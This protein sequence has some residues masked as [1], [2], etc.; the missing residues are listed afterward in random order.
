MY[1]G[2]IRI[3]EYDYELPEER[4]AQFPVNKRDQSKLLVYRNGNISDDN[5]SNIGDYIPAGSM[6]IFNNSKVIKARLLFGKETGA[7]IE[8]LCLEPSSPSDYENSFNARKTTEW[9]CI[10]GNLKKWKRGPVYLEFKYNG[11]T[12]RLMAEKSEAEGDLWRIRFRWDPEELRFEDV[13]EAAGHIPLP[14][15]ITR[16]DQESDITDYQTVY[17]E[18]KGSVAAPTAGLHFTSDVLSDLKN[19]NIS[20]SEVTLHVGAGTFKPVKSTEATEHEMHNEHF[21]VTKETLQKLINNQGKKIAVGTTSVR[22][23][24]SLYWIGVKLISSD[25]SE[26]ALRLGQW[27][28]YEI[29]SDVSENEAIKAVIKYLENKNLLSLYASTSIMIVPGYRFRLTEGIITNFH[30]PR[31]TLLLLISAW[32]GDNWKRIYGY[33]LENGFRFLSYGDSSILLR[34]Y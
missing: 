33:A 6:L 21:I 22:T 16:K 18:V 23:I 4:I 31:S 24:E 15:Y 12:G 5:F 25:F 9:K 30:Q 19:R 2:K 13:L 32:T 8:I 11:K 26:S 14:P 27:E 28:P 34:T 7:A 17:S 20:V 1:P 29:K 3:S 10:V